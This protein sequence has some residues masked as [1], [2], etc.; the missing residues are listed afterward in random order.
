M[1]KFVAGDAELRA[2]NHN[3]HHIRCWKVGL[4]LT[5]QLVIVSLSKIN[6]DSEHA[7]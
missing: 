3:L 7:N 2:L 6:Y 4:I 5:E 1:Q